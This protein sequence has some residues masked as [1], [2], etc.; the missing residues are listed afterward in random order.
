[1]TQELL[2]FQGWSKGLSAGL[3]V[4]FS[5]SLFI[6]LSSGSRSPILLYI[7]FFLITFS[8][9]CS[10][11]LFWSFQFLAFIERSFFRF[12]LPSQSVVLYLSTNRFIFMLITATPLPFYLISLSTSMFVFIY[13]DFARFPNPSIRIRFLL[14]L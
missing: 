4:P 8:L 5:S 6:L 10:R 9:S 12:T 11:Y 13:H 14:S 1:M 3:L 7:F 2:K